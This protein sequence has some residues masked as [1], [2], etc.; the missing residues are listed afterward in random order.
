MQ[1][2]KYTH[3]GQNG[4]TQFRVVQK[5]NNLPTLNS[6][7]MIT[8][9]SQQNKCIFTTIMY[10]DLQFSECNYFSFCLQLTAPNVGQKNLDVMSALREKKRRKCCFAADY[11]FNSV[12]DM[13]LQP[14][15]CGVPT[16]V[17]PL[18]PQSKGWFSPVHQ[19]KDYKT[20]ARA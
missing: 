2:Q 18:P 11:S 19:E 16:L 13:W 14:V 3:T 5:G 17:L 1:L 12:P 6:I 4:C 10:K 15:K 8:I 9:R 20:L 7:W